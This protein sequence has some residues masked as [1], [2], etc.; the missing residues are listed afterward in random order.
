M[1]P[2]AD[3]PRGF[4]FI[5][6]LAAM[7]FMALVVP[8]AMQGLLLANQVTQRA[9]R[10]RQAGALAERLLNEAIVTESWRDGDLAG[11]FERPWEG[12]DWR[13]TSQPWPEDTMRL[14]TVEVGYQVQDQRF[15]ERLSTLASEFAEEDAGLSE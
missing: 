4:T 5:E 9:T 15:V 3:R 2:Q 10:M 7:L 11:A 8:V 14:V 6:I 12:Y 1:R 13:I